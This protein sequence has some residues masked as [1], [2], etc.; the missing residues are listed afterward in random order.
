MVYFSKV[1]P[2]FPPR[3]Q[4]FVYFPQSVKCQGEQ[5]SPGK[6]IED[7]VFFSLFLGEK[8]NQERKIQK[9]R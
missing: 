5:I 6:K 9:I 7:V 4:L 1:D 2:G 8:E 3:N